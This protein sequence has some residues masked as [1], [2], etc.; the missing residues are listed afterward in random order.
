MSLKHIS[1]HVEGVLNSFFLF[2]S[3]F[4]ASTKMTN[5]QISK[6]SFFVCDYNFAEE[7]SCLYMNKKNN[8]S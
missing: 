3:S 6:F 7:T 4:Y 5:I 1:F 8:E 2:Y